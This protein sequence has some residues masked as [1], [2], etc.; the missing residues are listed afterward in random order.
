M[1]NG[2][3][4]SGSR[5]SLRRL[6]TYVTAFCIFTHESLFDDHKSECEALIA[7]E[8]AHGLEW[9]RTKALE[10]QYGQA[11]NKVTG[12]Y[13]NT[14]L[15]DEQIAEQK[16]V[17]QAAVTEI[18]GKLTIKVVKLNDGDYAELDDTQLAAFSAYIEI[19]KDAGVKIYK[20]SLPADSLKLTLDIF[21]DPLVLRSNGSRIDGGAQTPVADA[22]RAYLRNLLFNGEY[23]N[24]RLTDRLQQVEGVKLPVVRSAQAKYGLF[25]FAQIDERYIPD[26]G[27]LRLTGENLSINY[28][29]YV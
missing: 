6:W 28:R 13:D 14:G 10:F 12:L 4:V 11:F 5:T 27:Y 18:D 15:T 20:N 29:E 8:R 25:P 7:K 9:Y 24:V 21:Y 3:N 26:A 23:A 19:I 22:A 2:I 17:A 16:I 1:A